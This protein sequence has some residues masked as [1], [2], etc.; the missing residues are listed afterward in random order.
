VTGRGRVGSP[1][2]RWYNRSVQLAGC[3]SRC[4]EAG[5]LVAVPVHRCWLRPQL[6]DMALYS[7][8]HLGFGVPIASVCATSFRFSAEHLPN[9]AENGWP[10]SVRRVQRGPRPSLAACIASTTDQV[11]PAPRKPSGALSA[12]LKGTVQP[13]AAT[14]GR[15]ATILKL[16]APVGVKPTCCE[17]DLLPVVPRSDSMARSS[18]WLPSSGFRLSS[19]GAV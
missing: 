10:A 18:S 15:D 11:Q 14:R 19:R 9:Q 16:R 3:K 6:T 17:P 5:E 12:T 8:H 4:E 2:E 1:I 7:R 13:H